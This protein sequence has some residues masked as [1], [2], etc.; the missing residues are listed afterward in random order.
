MLKSGAGKIPPDTMTLVQFKSSFRFEKEK[1]RPP[2]EFMWH[3]VST[4]LWRVSI[5]W[6]ELNLKL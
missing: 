5:I 6:K 1:A 4:V 2:P 3:L